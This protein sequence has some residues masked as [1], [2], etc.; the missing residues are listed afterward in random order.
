MN[1]KIGN[2]NKINKSNIGH[3]IQLNN[4]S[5]KNTK[6]TFIKKHPVL[7]SVVVSF[8]VGFILLFSVWEGIVDWLESLLK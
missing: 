6:K 7:M 8:L 4:G 1:I 5:K 3:Q 2:K